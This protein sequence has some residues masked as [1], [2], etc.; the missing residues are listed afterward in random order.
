MRCCV[1]ARNTDLRGSAAGFVLFSAVLLPWTLTFLI[2][3]K[4]VRGLAG[5]HTHPPLP[6]PRPPKDRVRQKQGGKR[7]VDNSPARPTRVWVSRAAHVH[8]IAR[9]LARGPSRRKVRSVR[10]S[11]VRDRVIAPASSGGAPQRTL[12][13]G[14]K[15]AH[16]VSTV[17]R[18]GSPRPTGS[19][20]YRFECVRRRRDV[21]RDR[22]RQHERERLRV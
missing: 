4:A 21:N 6:S 17:A 7:G 13:H 14:A 19:R 22:T 20:T 1:V 2:G 10:T 9:P 16:A 5:L 18:V 12:G 11:R 15:R 8:L 3:G